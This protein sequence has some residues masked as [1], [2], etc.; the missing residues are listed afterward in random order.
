MAAYDKND[1]ID[2]E[3]V[4]SEVINLVPRGAAPAQCKLSQARH[5]ILINLIPELPPS[6]CCLYQFA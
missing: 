6:I 2:D 4:L 3:L 1:N 5:A